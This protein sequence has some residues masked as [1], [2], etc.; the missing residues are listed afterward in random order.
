MD[1]KTGEKVIIILEDDADYPENIIPHVPYYT[2]V[3]D[4]NTIKLASTK[5]D[6]DNGNAITIYY[7]GSKLRVLTRVID[8]IAG[9]AGH[10][11]QFDSSNRWYINVNSGNGIYTQLSALGVDGIGDEETEPTFIKRIPDIEVLMKRFISS[12]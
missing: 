11:V 5:K 7:S 8:K 4:S 3:V 2:I 10:P 1:L 6:A 12:E 9:D